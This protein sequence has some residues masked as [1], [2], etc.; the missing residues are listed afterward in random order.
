MKTTKYYG[1]V[2]EVKPTGKT[3]HKKAKSFRDFNGYW[4][5]Q[6]AEHWEQIGLYH[7]GA[8]VFTVGRDGKT[9]YDGAGRRV[10]EVSISDKVKV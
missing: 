10:G 1:I 7:E 3:R 5:E 4:T 2:Y 8:L 9:I 6:P